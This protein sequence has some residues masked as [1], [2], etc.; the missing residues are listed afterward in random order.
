MSNRA[1]WMAS[2][3]LGIAGCN[4]SSVFGDIPQPVSVDVAFWGSALE[5]GSVSRVCAFG[6]ASWGLAVATHRVD[7]WTLSDPTLAKVEQMPDPDD[8]YACIL[9]RPIRPG[10]LSVTARMAGLDGVNA[11]RLIPAIGVV[12]VRPSALTLSVGDTASI[13]A[14]VITVGGD[15]LRDIPILWRESDYG[16]ISTVVSYGI[17]PAAHSVVQA[18][19]AGQ[20]IVTAQAATSRQDSAT[21]VKGQAQITVTSR[22][23]P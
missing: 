13:T 19:V 1:L 22:Q 20:N 10:I 15:T 23:V 8:R 17:G 12:Q 21:N 16:V 11:V 2:C 18:D 14:T 7:S 4:T 9:L 5:V 6:M 3:L